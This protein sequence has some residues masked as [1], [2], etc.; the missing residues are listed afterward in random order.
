MWSGSTRTVINTP[1]STVFGYFDG[2]GMAILTGEAWT[3]MRAA[4]PGD[5]PIPESAVVLAGARDLD[6]R[7]QERLRASQITHLAP[8]DLERSDALIEAAENLGASGLYLHVDLDVL[9]RDEALVN[10]YSAPG[11]PSAAQLESA[12]ANCSSAS[13]YAR[14]RS[15]RTTRSATR[16]TGYRR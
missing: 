6:E 11:G 13:P 10:V 2:M 4:V 1:E 16:T 3:A 14:S 9:D 7:E 5:G 8:H 12:S 15:R